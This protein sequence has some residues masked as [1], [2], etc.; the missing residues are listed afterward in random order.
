ME[1]DYIKKIN[2]NWKNLYITDKAAKEK[3]ILIGRYIKERHNDGYAIYQI[4]KVTA[5]KV[6]IKVITG[7]GD[8]WTIPYWGKKASVD[9]TYAQSNIE[10]RDRQS[11]LFDSINTKA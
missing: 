9:K 1:N 6:K 2:E 7:I 11:K 4:I 10:T 8:D 5:K 3:G